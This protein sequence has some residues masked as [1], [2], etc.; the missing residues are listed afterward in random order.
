MNTVRILYRGSLSSCNYSCDYCPFA[1]TKNTPEELRLDE[2]QLLRF[3]EWVEGVARPVGILLTP[4]GEAIVHGYYR[5]AMTRLSQMPHVQ[6]TALQTNLSAPLDDFQHADKTS[7]ALWAT[8]HPTQVRLPVFVKRCEA[9]L[10]A[11]IRFSVG[12]VGLKQHFDQIA[13]LRQQIPN[14]I[15]VWVN[16]YKRQADYYQESDAAFLRSIDPYFDLNRIHYSSQAKP[17]GAGESSFTVDGEGDVHRCHFVDTKIGN[18][19][20]EDIFQQLQ[21]RLCPNA[22]CGC[23]IG[24]VHRPQLKLNQLF[25]DNLLERIPADWPEVDP[26]FVAA[27]EVTPA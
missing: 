1:K 15:Y 13:E 4:W 25:G 3:V 16:A 26:G 17:C 12:V 10:D 2:R 18:I 6:R 27:S 11:D 23:H 8:Y 7:L 5:Q 24:Y 20:Q 21:P 22:G 14:S 19:Y 9:L